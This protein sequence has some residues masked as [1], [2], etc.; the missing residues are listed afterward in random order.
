MEY[1][2]SVKM[3]NSLLRDGRQIVMGQLKALGASV[4]IPDHHLDTYLQICAPSRR[5]ARRTAR[6]KSVLLNRFAKKL[7]H[8]VLRNA[9]DI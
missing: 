9:R 6:T 1:T 3:F 8:C 4:P 2:R 7:G 5:S